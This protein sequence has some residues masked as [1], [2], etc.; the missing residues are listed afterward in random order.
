MFHAGKCALVEGKN[1]SEPVMLSIR[2]TAIIVA[3]VFVFEILPIRFIKD[4]I[5]FFFPFIFD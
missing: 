2:S 1:A 5:C 3:V 4:I